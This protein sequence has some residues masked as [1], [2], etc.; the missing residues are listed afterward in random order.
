M[1]S[2]TVTQYGL[3]CQ[4]QLILFQFEQIVLKINLIFSQAHPDREKLV[5]DTKN[6]IKAATNLLT[7]RKPTET[8]TQY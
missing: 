4:P 2:E 3:P 8:L 5:M 6:T 7:T 1:F